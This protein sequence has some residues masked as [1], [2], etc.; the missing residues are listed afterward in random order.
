MIPIINDFLG[1]K[2]HIHKDESG[3]S[4][5]EFILTF[6]FALGVT[7]LFV[8]QAR[9][10]TEGYLVHYANFMASRAYLTYDTGGNN[11]QGIIRDA[12]DFAEDVFK[13][14]KLQI[15]G[16]EAKFE[17][18]DRNR[19]SALFSGTV[20]QFEKPLSSLPVV[21]KKNVY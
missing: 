12:G 2:M 3:Q 18:I 10:M 8:N 13:D 17:V 19:G 16:V 4:A 5:I 11:K 20:A 6:A 15:F 14:Y 9:N 7:F 1:Q 21:G